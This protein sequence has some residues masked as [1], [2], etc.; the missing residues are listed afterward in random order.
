M[1]RSMQIARMVSDEIGSVNV[2]RSGDSNSRYPT[3][4]QLCNVD[5]LKSDTV[6]VESSSGL[7]TIHNSRSI[8][9]TVIR[10]S[11]GSA[12]FIMKYDSV[13]NNVTMDICWVIA[14]E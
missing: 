12:L 14:Q 5:C 1:K 11:T 6:T 8:I 2:R 13:E 3:N 10:A 9:S 4:R 7:P